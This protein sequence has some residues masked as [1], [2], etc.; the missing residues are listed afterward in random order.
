MKCLQTM[1]QIFIPYL[2]ICKN[3]VST[4]TFI[5][6]KYENDICAEQLLPGIDSTDF[7]DGIVYLVNPRV[8]L[9]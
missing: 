3:R 6:D 1:K 8:V 7:I 9:L 2:M 5:S 4:L